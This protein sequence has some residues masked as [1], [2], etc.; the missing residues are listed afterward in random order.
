M[1]VRLQWYIFKT[2]IVKLI[3]KYPKLMKS[4]VAWNY[5]KT[6]FKDI[7]EIQWRLIFANLIRCSRLHIEKVILSFLNLHLCSF[8]W[9]FF[10]SIKGIIRLI[11]KGM[12]SIYLNINTLKNLHSQNFNFLSLKNLSPGQF[13]GTPTH[14]YIIE[15]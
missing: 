2:N 4:S 8:T 11:S 6:F 5:L 15:F 7:K 14:A 13:R 3:N 10:S 1:F 12:S 9:M